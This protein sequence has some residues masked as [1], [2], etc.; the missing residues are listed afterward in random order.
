MENELK[1]CPFCGG[2]AQMMHK[3]CKSIG[4]A[5]HE[6]AYIYSFECKK[7]GA[8]TSSCGYKDFA[9]ERWN[10]RTPDQS[11]RIAKLEAE[12]QVY[13]E[14]SR[15]S[16]AIADHETARAEKAEATI[17]TLREALEDCK[18]FAEMSDEVRDV[19]RLHELLG[20]VIYTSRK[21]LALTGKET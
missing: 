5:K 11:L 17:A 8:K 1:P 13:T 4:K 16:R 20:S 2:Q 6:T 18:R 21:V 14:N 3:L 12:V 19:V 9:T 7:C 15:T 10:T